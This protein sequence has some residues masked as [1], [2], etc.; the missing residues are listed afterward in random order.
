[1]AGLQRISERGTVVTACARNSSFFFEFESWMTYGNVYFV[2]VDPAVLARLEEKSRKISRAMCR[3][4]LD[5]RCVEN[6]LTK[7]C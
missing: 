2:S 5:V 7:G 6:V 4:R 1:M 3:K